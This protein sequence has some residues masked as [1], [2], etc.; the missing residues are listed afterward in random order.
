LREQ[1]GERFLAGLVLH[2]GP[3]IYPLDEQITAAP[4]CTIWG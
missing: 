3:H 4:I 1:F 2:T